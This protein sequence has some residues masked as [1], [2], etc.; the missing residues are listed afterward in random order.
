MHTVTKRHGHKLIVLDDTWWSEPEQ[1][2]AAPALVLYTAGMTGPPRGVVYSHRGLALQV[3]ASL[4][5]QALQLEASFLQA[6]S[7]MQVRSRPCRSRRSR[8]WPLQEALPS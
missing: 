3:E 5:V 1:L 4:L 7:S 2:A 6:L 8:S